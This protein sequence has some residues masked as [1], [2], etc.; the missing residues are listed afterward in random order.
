MWYRDKK[1]EK[2]K[3]LLPVA[4]SVC[5]VITQV[6]LQ[7]P[8]TRWPVTSP[9]L[10]NSVTLQLLT[11]SCSESWESWR[12]ISTQDGRDDVVQNVNSIRAGP[13]TFCNR[14][15]ISQC[16]NEIAPFHHPLEIIVVFVSP[17]ILFNFRM[18]FYNNSRD[19]IK[20]ENKYEEWFRSIYGRIG[21]WR[22]IVEN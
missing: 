12:R 6:K 22:I 10:P 8:A 19:E 18:N 3:H 4:G 7:S 13:D 16:I 2:R 11:F 5:Y 17:D 15:D 1:K 21:K 9:R 20:E 14:E